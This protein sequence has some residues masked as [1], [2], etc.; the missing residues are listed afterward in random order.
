MLSSLCGA[1]EDSPDGGCK[2]RG[3]I[4]VWIQDNLNHRVHDP[5]ERF[6][7]ILGEEE[8]SGLATWKTTDLDRKALRIVINHD[9]DVMASQADDVVCW[10]NEA[11]AR[12]GGSQAELT[13]ACRKAIPVYL[14]SELPLDRTRG[15]VP[16]QE[17][18]V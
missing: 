2:W 17:F 1:M 15:W 16:R 9:L 10:W 4:R 3:C 5:C 12:G 7:R 11:A 14:V 18:S 8:L 13:A 6:P